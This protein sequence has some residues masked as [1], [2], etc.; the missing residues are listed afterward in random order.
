MTKLKCLLGVAVLLLASASIISGFDISGG[1]IDKAIPPGGHIS[2]EVTI[3][4]T[5]SDVP[6]NLSSEVKGII[7]SLD[8]STTST[9]ADKDDYSYSARSFLS[10]SPTS[11]QLEP[12]DSQTVLLEG[13][14]PDDIGPGTR[15]AI[16]SILSTPI[17][18]SG[19][20]ASTTVLGQVN[21]PI[22][23]DIQG[24]DQIRT[25]DI[26][27]LKLEEP[28]SA[29]NQKLSLIFENTGNTQ[30][31]AMVKADLLDENGNVTYSTSGPLSVAAI[32][33]GTSRLFEFAITPDEELEPGSYAINAT[34]TL[35]DGSVLAY[36]EM[37]FEI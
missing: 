19:K 7:V 33:P 10:V 5:D 15:Y 12:G 8:G 3:T 26:S 27:D 31:R 13:D 6:S 17:S 1:V 35:Q 24:T 11:F 21:L 4:A 37:E 16:L 9:S 23:I 30:F 22:I 25:G 2:H 29:N 20:G 36:K 34:I 14:I 18:D 32:L 28:S